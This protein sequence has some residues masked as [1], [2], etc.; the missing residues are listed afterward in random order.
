[1]LD[2]EIFALFIARPL[3]ETLAVRPFSGHVL[4]RFERA[5]NLIDGQGRII[6]LTL[7]EVG[8]GPFSIVVAGQPELFKSLW[9]EQPAYTDGQDLVIGSCRVKLGVAQVWEP[10]LACFCQPL[11][12]SPV[13][14]NMLRPYTD[15]PPLSGATPVVKNTD[16]LAGEVAIRL[17]LALIQ[18]KEVERLENWGEIEAA[19][20]QLAGLGSGLTPA[21]DDYLIGVMAALWLSGY[22]NWPPKIAAKAAPLTTTLSA[23]FLQ[24]A[25][26]GEFIEPWHELAQAL[27]VGRAEA[28]GQALRRVAQFG[29]SS[30]LDALAGFTMT[31]SGD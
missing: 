5:C 17:K 14:V 21:G 19:V 27:F 25:G 31:L 10:R 29:A 30:G 13:L 26:R 28:F 23:A 8:N 22:K 24:A 6:A 4:G 2:Q 20:Q 16:R 15:W 1:M 3:V 11:E 7:P 9:V 18:Y 12:V